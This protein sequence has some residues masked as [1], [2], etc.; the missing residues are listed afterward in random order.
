M[1]GLGLTKPLRSQLGISFSSWIFIADTTLSQFG[2]AGRISGYLQF[3][4]VKRDS[5]VAEHGD[6]LFH[7]QS[8]HD[9][10]DVPRDP[11]GPILRE[12]RRSLEAQGQGRPAVSQQVKPGPEQEF[13]Q[14]LHRLIQSR[15]GLS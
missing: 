7:D 9:V 12:E 14:G 13:N 15:F 4:W 6:N 10:E 8:V 5:S 2:L 1:M 11:D 3:E